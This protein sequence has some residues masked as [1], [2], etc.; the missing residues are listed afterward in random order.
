MKPT[1]NQVPLD[2]AL[3]LL[4]LSLKVIL[5]GPSNYNIIDLALV[6]S[7]SVASLRFV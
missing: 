7:L 3:A 4:C 5:P 6:V 2:I 1:L